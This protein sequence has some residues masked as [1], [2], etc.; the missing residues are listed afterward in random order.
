MHDIIAKMQEYNRLMDRL[1][2]A[3][4]FYNNENI[5]I[6]AKE[7]MNDEY[8]RLVSDLSKLFDEITELGYTFKEQDTV[9]GIG[10]WD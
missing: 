4:A 5:P 6:D 10:R 8:I 9:Y 1:N 3:E 7:K 2:K